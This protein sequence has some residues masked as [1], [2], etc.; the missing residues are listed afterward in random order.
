MVLKS[1]LFKGRPH[2]TLLIFIL[3]PAFPVHLCEW[4]L[5]DLKWECGAE[6]SSVFPDPESDHLSI[7]LIWSWPRQQT[8]CSHEFLSHL[9]SGVMFE[10]HCPDIIARQLLIPTLSK[11][12]NLCNLL[13]DLLFIHFLWDIQMSPHSLTL[14]RTC[15][16]NNHPCFNKA[17]RQQ[18]WACAAIQGRR[19]TQPSLSDTSLFTSLQ[20]EQHYLCAYWETVIPRFTRSL[21]LL[22]S[23]YFSC[24]D[25]RSTR[26]NPVSLAFPFDTVDRKSNVQQFSLKPHGCIRQTVAISHVF[27]KSPITC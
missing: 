18:L 27:P 10:L 2:L 4:P 16:S 3:A 25:Q 23:C 20:R 8:K 6:L 14:T 13:I 15:T 12:W 5:S 7:A 11:M 22:A 17:P 9:N 1:D 21:L 26:W 19:E 24:Q